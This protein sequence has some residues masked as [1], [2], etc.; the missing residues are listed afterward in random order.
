MFR[1]RKTLVVSKK[2]PDPEIYNLAKERL[3][4]NGNEC[5]V[6]EDSRN[7]LLAAKAAGMFCV[8]TTN[9]YTEDEDFRQAD[10]VHSELGE[11]PNVLVTLDNL[12]RICSA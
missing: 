9:G 11:P 6:I 12:K 8:V 1:K 5:V 10:A 2:K 7:G 3:G 4:V